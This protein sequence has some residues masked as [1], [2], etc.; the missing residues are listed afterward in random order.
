MHSAKH[1]DIMNKSSKGRQK[2][3]IGV[4][5]AEGP[6]VPIP[7]TEVKLSGAEDTWLVTAWEN[8]EMPIQSSHPIGWLFFCLSSDCWGITMVKVLLC[9]VFILLAAILLSVGGTML[10]QLFTLWKKCRL[11]VAAAVSGFHLEKR[12]GTT[13]YFPVFEF[14][15]N[16][17]LHQVKSRF[18]GKQPRYRLGESITL[19]VDPHYFGRFYEGREW[20]FTALLCALCCFTGAVFLGL[21]FLFAFST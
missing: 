12:W 11:E 10:Q 20:N 16:G 9:G 2:R 21:S 1:D 19:H 13:R 17:G 18:G 5:D 14:E 4:D 3:I 6:P 15:A 7:N 8:R